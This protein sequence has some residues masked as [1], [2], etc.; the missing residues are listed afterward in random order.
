M[1]LPHCAFAY[2]KIKVLYIDLGGGYMGAICKNSMSCTL[3]T[4][5]LYSVYYTLMEK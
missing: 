3:Q 5:A 4:C 1:K 2:L